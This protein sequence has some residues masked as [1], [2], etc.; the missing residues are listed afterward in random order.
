MLSCLAFKL[1]LL[2]VPLLLKRRLLLLLLLYTGELLRR[3]AR[4]WSC[5]RL[6]GFR[7]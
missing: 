5:Q 6:L 7:W 3:H 1:L 4:G 2:D